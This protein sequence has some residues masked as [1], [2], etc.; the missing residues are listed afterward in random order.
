MR[1]YT[2]SGVREWKLVKT[3]G[4]QILNKI[5]L[6]EGMVGTKEACE[7]FVQDKRDAGFERVSNIKK[8]KRP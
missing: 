7:Q 2:V 8:W 5:P 4:G 6:T 1:L 3:P